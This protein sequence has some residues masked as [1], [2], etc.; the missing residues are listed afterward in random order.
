MTQPS[1]EQGLRKYAIIKHTPSHLNDYL[2][3]LSLTP[4]E[5]ISSGIIYPISHYHS[6]ANISHTHTKY[7]LSLTAENEH[8]TYNQAKTQECWV[9]AMNFELLALQQNKTWVFVDLSQVVRLTGRRRCT[10]LNTRQMENWKYT[11]L[12]WLQKYTIK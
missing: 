9:Q 12:N 5:S 3:N 10:K 2:C 7:L 4:T 11:K 6:Y 8:V 1:F